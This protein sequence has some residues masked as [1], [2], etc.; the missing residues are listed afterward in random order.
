MSWLR[1]REFSAALCLGSGCFTEGSDGGFGSDGPGA[2][3]GA[4]TSGA[5]K[6]GTET[7]ACQDGGR[8][9][10]GLVCASQLCVDLGG[11]PDPSAAD[12]GAEG[13]T[14]KTTDD[15]GETVSDTAV[16]TGTGESGAVGEPGSCEGACG[17]SAPDFDG[18]CFCDPVCGTMN[19]C[20]DDYVT[21]CAGGCLF[22]DDC[23]EAEVCS[24]GGGGCIAA[25]GATY[26]VVVEQWEDHTPTCW[27]IAPDCFADVYYRVYYGGD[28]VFTSSTQDN[29]VTATWADPWSSVIDSDAVLRF[30]FLDEDNLLDDQ[31]NDECFLDGVGSCGPVPS[32]VL[33]AGIAEW[34]PD[35]ES[36]VVRVR[37][38]AQ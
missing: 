20:C 12:D 3:T 6:P 11:G 17:G 38:L 25:F 26:D 10:P 28:P 19:D 15:G 9:D 1:W 23:S 29:A 27:D 14:A 33:H 7:C 36:F 35:P 30:S 4:E 13:T 8:C 2:D 22:N 37:F 21:A 34:T 31:L 24:I 5:C 32:S 16:D 18:T